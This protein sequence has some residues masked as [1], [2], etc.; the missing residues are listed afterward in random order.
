VN[1][2]WSKGTT[3]HGIVRVVEQ[4]PDSAEA[5]VARNAREATAS[6]DEMS[7]PIAVGTVVARQGPLSCYSSVINSNRAVR[8]GKE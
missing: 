7:P 1:V 8:S 5:E 4:Y 2:F 6:T 3:C